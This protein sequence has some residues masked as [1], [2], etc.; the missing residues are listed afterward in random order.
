MENKETQAQITAVSAYSGPLPPP[1]ALIKYNE[2]SPGAADRIILMAEKEMEHR[3]KNE[4]KI[5]VDRIRLSYIS[6]ILFFVSVVILS[7]LVGYGLY[8]GADGVAVGAAIGAIASVAG[9][10]I[11]AKVR[12]N[13]KEE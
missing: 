3:H 9:L 2:A 12:Q 7:V 8:L 13:K 6:I 10:F 1:E 4:D 5:L 11:Y